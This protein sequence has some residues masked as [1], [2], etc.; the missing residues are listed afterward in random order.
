MVT[1]VLYICAAVGV[2]VFAVMLY[3]VAAFHAST[4]NLGGRETRNVALEILW[5]SI[6]ILIILAALVPIVRSLPS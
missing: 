2:A 3:S 6:P 4:E 1:A 5:S